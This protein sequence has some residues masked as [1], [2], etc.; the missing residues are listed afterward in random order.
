MSK[1][2]RETMA[3]EMERAWLPDILGRFP[4]HR[5]RA[6]A[7]EDFKDAGFADLKAV[8]EYMYPKVL[9]IEP[10]VNVIFPEIKQTPP[11]KPKQDFPMTALLGV[12]EHQRFPPPGAKASDELI[13]QLYARYEKYENA[14]GDDAGKYFADFITEPATMLIR[15]QVAQYVFDQRVRKGW[16]TAIEP[17]PEARPTSRALTERERVGQL[18]ALLVSVSD[19][20]RNIPLF[21]LFEERH[22]GRGDGRNMLKYFK[23]VAERSKQSVP[24]DAA[25]WKAFTQRMLESWEGAA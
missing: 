8:I 17:D 25:G 14:R 1:R 20:I 3:E 22:G 10:A 12:L 9:E 5:I 6:R 13:D 16:S 15:F 2:N 24:K 19:D 18:Q 4:L 11:A 23:R 21:T 7:I